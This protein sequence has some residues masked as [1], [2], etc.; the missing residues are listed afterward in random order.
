MS[1]HVAPRWGDVSH[2]WVI[3]LVTLILHDERMDPVEPPSAPEFTRVLVQVDCRTLIK[4]VCKRCGAWKLV[5]HL[6]ESLEMWEDTHCCST[7]QAE[8]AGT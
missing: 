7:G 3:T 8:N 1:R 6:D 2:E 5:S 4:S